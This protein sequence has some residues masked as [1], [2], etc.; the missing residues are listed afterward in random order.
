MRIFKR[1]MLTA[2]AAGLPLA[3]C[4]PLPDPEQQACDDAGREGLLSTA[5][6]LADGPG[7]R[8]RRRRRG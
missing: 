2:V 4:A 8:E 6:R 3:A 5:G 7:R 1:L